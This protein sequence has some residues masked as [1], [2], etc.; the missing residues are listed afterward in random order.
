MAAS[1]HACKR[2]WPIHHPWLDIHDTACGYDE[3]M[4]NANCMGC[5]RRRQESALDQ[6]QRINPRHGV[7]GLSK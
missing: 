4:T 2:P 5:H 7:D 6:L 3:R 1:S